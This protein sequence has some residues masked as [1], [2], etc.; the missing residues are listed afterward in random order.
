M[1]P[2][3]PP[4]AQIQDAFLS[5]RNYFNTLDKI[6]KENRPKLRKVKEKLSTDFFQDRFNYASYLIDV[7]GI[8]VYSSIISLYSVVENCFKMLTMEISK[9]IKLPFIITDFNGSLS[10]QLRFY[11]AASKLNGISENDYSAISIFTKIRN[12]VVH[13]NGNISKENSKLLRIIKFLK[14]IEIKDGKL[15][16]LP[17][18]CELKLSDFELLFNKIESSNNDL[19]H[20]SYEARQRNV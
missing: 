15:Y 14:H 16:I 9:G 6:I 11:T 5:Y 13:D 17:I 19:L 20:L 12:C 4:F 1:R 10:N 18:Y 3:Y 7:E 2:H 8:F